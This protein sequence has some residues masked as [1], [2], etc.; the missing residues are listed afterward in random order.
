M[1]HDRRGLDNRLTTGRCAPHRRRIVRPLR[2][3]D[4]V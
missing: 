2:E 3:R 4:H 1:D